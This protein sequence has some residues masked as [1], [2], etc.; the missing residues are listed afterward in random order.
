MSK[1]P[2]H[3]RTPSVQL[4]IEATGGPIG[5]RKW[6]TII[7]RN[8]KY[9]GSQLAMMI[10]RSSPIVQMIS[11]TL[12]AFYLL[13]FTFESLTLTLILN[14]ASV[15]SPGQWLWSSLA[16]LI[17]PYIEFHWYNILIDIF[18]VSLCGT[19]I[20]PLWGHKEVGCYVC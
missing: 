14:P 4:K 15:L 7:I 13:S 1:A 10:S 5:H 17:H 12:I 16:A 18:I 8:C 6:N 19:L 2:D 3:N 9:F 20:E 11:I